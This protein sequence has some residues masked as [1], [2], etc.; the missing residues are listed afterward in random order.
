MHTITKT[1]NLLVTAAA[2]LTLSSSCKKFLSVAPPGNQLTAPQLFS[3]DS[4]LRQSVTGLYI[5]AMNKRQFLFNGALSVYPSLSADEISRTLF[6][7]DETQFNTN[8]LLSTNAIITTNIWSEAY[9]FIYQTNICL[10]GLEKAQQLNAGEKR[11][12]VGEVRF[13]RALCY[14]YLVNLFGNV[15]LVTTSSL[16]TNRVIAR[17]PAAEVY[18]LIVSDLLYAWT[19]MS[20]QPTT[21]TRAHKYAAGALLARVYCYLQ[22]W[23]N[24]ASFS[25]AVISSLQYRLETDV[26][27]VFLESSPET[28]LQFI[29]VIPNISTSEAQVFIPSS[30]L[31]MPTYTITPQLL[32]AFEVND[33][34]RSNWIKSVIINGTEYHYPVKYRENTI[35]TPRKEH[36]IVLRLAEQHLIRAEARAHLDQLPGAIDDINL[37]R[38]RAQLNNLHPALNADQCLAT[39]EQERRVEFFTEWGHRWLDLKRTNKATA[40]L[41]PVKN[42]NWQSTDQWY[43]IPFD[44]IRKNPNLQQNDGY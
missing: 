8:A 33:K 38:N 39:I 2:L 17:S 18:T 15:P 1:A 37:V 29:P 41:A 21:N 31:N 4:T 9:F 24:A 19:T 28:I 12:L 6:A 11:Q 7:T 20:D 16:E 25:H 43:P 3:V 32:A 42:N 35:A 40:V 23:S 26:N 5:K 13:L 34:R 30:P 14:V 22:D 36:N 44:E 27:K 10:E